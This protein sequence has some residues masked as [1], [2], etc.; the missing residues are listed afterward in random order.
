MEE[1]SDTYRAVEGE[2]VVAVIIV[3]TVESGIY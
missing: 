2:A 3:V 1:E